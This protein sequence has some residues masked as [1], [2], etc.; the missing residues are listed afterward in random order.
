MRLFGLVDGKVDHHDRPLT[1]ALL[2]TLPW[3]VP[4]VGGLVVAGQA[5]TPRPSA[6]QAFVPSP[7][8]GQAYIPSPG[9]G[10]YV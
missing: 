3:R 7:V 5:Y 9:A 1:F 4:I 8:V 2:F 10:Q 6:A